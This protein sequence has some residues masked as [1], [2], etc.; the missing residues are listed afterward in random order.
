MLNIV[1]ALG[2][3]ARK[4]DHV[5]AAVLFRLIDRD[6]PTLLLDEADNQD[7]ANNPTLRSV[8]NSGHHCDGK[9][10]RY[11]GLRND[12][13]CIEIDNRTILIQVA[14]RCDDVLRLQAANGRTVTVLPLA[15]GAV[16]DETPGLRRSQL[17]QTGPN[18]IHLRSFH[19]CYGRRANEVGLCDTQFHD[20]GVGA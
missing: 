20:H 3:R 18:T 7:L 14:G 8:I 17:I 6:R 16:I 9:I 2:C 15:I 10:M 12:A 4:T 11:L 13:L 5:T 19:G 1:K